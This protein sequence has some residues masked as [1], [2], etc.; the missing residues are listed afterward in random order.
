MP[1]HVSCSSPS[2]LICPMTAWHCNTFCF[3]ANFLMDIHQYWVNFH[4]KVFILRGVDVQYN[5][6]IRAEGHAAVFLYVVIFPSFHDHLNTVYMWNTVFIF[7][8]SWCKA[9]H[10]NKL[11]HDDV[12][13]WKHFR[14]S[15][16]LTLCGGNTPVTGGFPS[17]RPATRNVFCDLCL[18]KR[19]SKQSRRR[20]FETPSR[21]L[22]RHWRINKYGW[23]ENTNK[24]ATYCKQCDIKFE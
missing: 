22:W 23:H 10:Y 16:L 5:E 11:L 2:E 15:T 4:H 14:V 7:D 24:H 19:L 6:N 3:A 13:K 17:L 8:R 9:V 21:S 20:W 12:I 18:N 1:R